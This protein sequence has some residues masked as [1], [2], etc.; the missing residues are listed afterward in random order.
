VPEGRFSIVDM[1]YNYGQWQK[2]SQWWGSDTAFF[3]ARFIWSALHNFGGTDG[4]KGNLSRINEMPFAAMEAGTRIWGT[5][6]TAEGIDQN[7][8]YYDILL[9]QPWLTA[10]RPDV[11]TSLVARAHR[12]YGLKAEMPEVADAWRLLAESMYV[13]DVSVQDSTGVGHLPGKATWDFAGNR[14]TPARDL[15]KTFDAWSKLVAAAPKVTAVHEPFRYDL[16]NLGRDVLA[17]LSTPFSMN[18]SDAISPHKGPPHTANVSAAGS[19]YLELLED[20]DALLGTDPAFLLGPWLAT[21]RRFGT[22]ESDCA[23]PGMPEIAT[24]ENFYEWNARVQITT[25]N[26]TPRGAVQIPGGP[27]DYAA[28]HWNGLVS[29]YYRERASRIMGLALK[30]AAAKRPLDQASVDR[31]KAA[32]AYEWTTAFG[33][34]YPEEPTGDAVA[35]SQKMLRKYSM[36]FGTCASGPQAV[37]V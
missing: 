9:G 5:G 2:F 15:C 25:W 4:L 21:A 30:A 20:L 10:R 24:C 8:A 6:F 11:A 22:G 28:K 23:V 27:I 1:D 18:F 13:Q 31:A 17:R 29:G 7:P 16:V 33:V 34:R 32:L 3:G 12:R 35:V 36:Y 19:L 14:R 37:F 26:P